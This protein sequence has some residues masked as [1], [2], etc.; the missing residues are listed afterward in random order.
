MAEGFAYSVLG[1][2]QIH[3]IVRPAVTRP[4]PGETAFQLTEQ[5]IAVVAEAADLFREVK[6]MR[7]AGI[8]IN[9]SLRLRL[10]QYAVVLSR[11]R[12]FIM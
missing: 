1:Y 5:I 3:R 10:H 12:A 11:L 7:F 4:I 2:V 9:D 6:Q 8:F